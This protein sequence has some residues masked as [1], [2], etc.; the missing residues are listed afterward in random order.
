M[1]STHCT[2]HIHKTN[3]HHP[4][5]YVPYAS[6]TQQI[7][8]IVIVAMSLL[9]PSY[10]HPVAE[11]FAFFL[12]FLLLFHLPNLTTLLPFYCFHSYPHRS[13]H[14]RH[15]THRNPNTTYLIFQDMTDVFNVC[16]Y[17]ILLRLSKMIWQLVLCPI[18]IR[19]CCLYNIQ[20]HTHIVR[21]KNE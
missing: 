14:F 5:Q 7:L 16:N 15:R 10:H 12:L 19:S 9:L 13:H 6:Y 8:I 11:C 4:L 3:T 2:V 1:Y 21:N 17:H 20:A 18:N